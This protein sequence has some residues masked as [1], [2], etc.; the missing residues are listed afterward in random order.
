MPKT[1]I[2]GVVFGL[3]MSYAMAY[4][5]EVYNVAIK[6]GFN[7]NIG[8]FSTMTNHV[9]LDAL[10]E[11]SYMGIFV[12]ITSSLWGNR[13]GAAFAARHTNPETD[14]PYFCRVM[15]QAGT[16]AIMCP[17]MSM[18]ASILFNV[19]L[20]HQPICNLPAIWVGTVIKNLPMAFFWNMFAAAP[21]THWLF[22]K[23]FPEKK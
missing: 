11:A 8:G 20:A 4:G 16:V 3:I 23:I 12:F 5:M 7:L 18:I 1:K 17:T 14:N 19:I 22:G 10:I 2:Q 9:F 6:E 21:F 13:I 15:R